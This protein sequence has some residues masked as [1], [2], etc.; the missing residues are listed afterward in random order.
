MVGKLRREPCQHSERW[1][2]QGVPLPLRCRGH[3]EPLGCCLSAQILAGPPGAR[4]PRG[5][6]ASAG[7]PGR[8]LGVAHMSAG[9]R[10]PGERS[11]RPVATKRVK[12][13]F[14]LHC[15][16]KPPR[17]DAVRARSSEVGRERR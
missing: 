6:R 11:G 16:E 4:R 3:S 2:L 17:A 1:G 9:S 13:Y 8:V 7:T 5:L 14:P 10:S 12:V 15:P